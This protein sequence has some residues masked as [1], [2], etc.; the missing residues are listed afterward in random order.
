[1]PSN[2]KINVDVGVNFKAE[3]ADLTKYLQEVQSAIQDM[4]KNTGN[5]GAFSGTE[6][7]IQK[8]IES[9][10]KLKNFKLNSSN[11]VEF[12][13]NVDKL[14]NNLNNLQ[15]EFNTENTALENRA[16]KYTKNINAANE[17][18]NLHKAEIEALKEKRTEGTRLTTE[19]TKQV[20]QYNSRLALIGRMNSLLKENNLS[21]EDRKKVL[22]AVNNALRQEENVLKGVAAAN[23][24]NANNEAVANK[25]SVINAI[26]QKIEY[27]TGLA[28]SIRLLR[29]QLK[30][31]IQTFQEVDKSITSISM[32]SGIS[33]DTLWNNIGDYNKLAQ[34]LGTTTKDVLQASQ[35]YYQQGRNSL[36]VVELTRESLTLAA[37]AGLETADATNYLTAAVN[38]YKMAASDA[39]QVTDVWAQL[40]AKNAVSVKELAVSISKVASIAQSAGMDIQSTSVFLTQMIATTREAPENLGTALKTIIARFQ[41]LKTSTEALE[42]GVD[43]NKVEKALKTVGISLRDTTG[44]FRDFD[45]VILELSSKWDSLDRNT[46]RYIATI[47][48]GSRQ[49]SRFIALVS[50]YE[51]LTKIMQEAS[52]ADGASA[53]QFEI[54][55]SGLEAALKRVK[56]AWENFYLSFSKGHNIV[57]RVA[58][59]ITKILNGASKIGSGLTVALGLVSAALIR[60]GMAAFSTGSGFSFMAG[61]TFTAKVGMLAYA[62]ATGK[63]ATA[64]T[65][66]NASN[67]VG[68]VTILIGAL[69]TLIPLLSNGANK[70][71][72]LKERIAETNEKSAELAQ[73]AAQLQ[74]YAKALRDANLAGEDDAEIRQQIIAL[75][76]ESLKNL[77]LETMAY[78]DLAKAMEIAARKDLRESVKENVNNL[79]NQRE[80]ALTEE[81]NRIRDQHADNLQD[82]LDEMANDEERAFLQLQMDESEYYQKVLDRLAKERAKMPEMAWSDAR[83]IGEDILGF[84]LTPEELTRVADA[85]R[86]LG[87]SIYYYDDSTQ[88]YASNDVAGLRE[89]ATIKE[90]LENIHSEDLNKLIAEAGTDAAKNYLNS[91]LTQINEQKAQVETVIRDLLYTPSYNLSGDMTLVQTGLQQSITSAFNNLG[92]IESAAA[93]KFLENIGQALYDNDDELARQITDWANTLIQSGIDPEDVSV[94]MIDLILGSPA[95]IEEAFSQQVEILADGSVQ[96]TDLGE[97]LKTQI[98]DSTAAFLEFNSVISQTSSVLSDV[99]K[100]IGG[101]LTLDQL[102]ETIMSLSLHWEEMGYSSRAAAVEALYAASASD[103]AGYSL[104][105]ES[106]A[107]QN[108]IGWVDLSTEATREEAIEKAQAAIDKNNIRIEELK[109]EEKRVQGIINGLKL[110]SGAN[111]DAYETDATNANNF[112]R[113]ITGIA[114]R[115]S[116]ALDTILGTNTADSIGAWVDETFTKKQSE[117]ESYE[118]QLKDIQDEIHS[119]DDANAVYQSV[120]GRAQAYNSRAGRKNLGGSS[121]SNGGSGSSEKTATENT[122]KLSEAMKEAAEAAKNLAKQMQDSMK[123]EIEAAKSRLEAL[124]ADAEKRKKLAE[125][126]L[127]DTQW[128]MKATLE[129][130]KEYIEK[131]LDL[132]Q[133]KIDDEKKLLKKEQDELQ[134]LNDDLRLQADAAQDAYDLKIDFVQKQI[135]ALNKEAEAEDR[136]RKLQEARDAY[137]RSRNQRTRLVLTQGAGWIFKTDTEALNQARDGLKDAQRDYQK[138]VLQDE[139]DKYE[140]AKKQVADLANNIGESQ[141]YMN[142]LANATNEW[143]S[144]IDSDKLE[145]LILF[146]ELQS[147]VKKSNTTTDNVRNHEKEIE[148]LEEDYKAKSERAQATIDDISERIERVGWDDHDYEVQDYKNSV[149]KNLFNGDAVLSGEKTLDELLNQDKYIAADFKSFDSYQRQ[150]NKT[151]LGI[152]D[153]VESID[154]EIKN[155]NELGKNIGKNA[156]ELAK[157]QEIAKKYENASF[158]ELKST[159]SL[160]TDLK[161][162]IGNEYYNKN[163]YDTTKIE[164]NENAWYRKL[165]KD[166]KEGNIT[167]TEAAYW[168]EVLANQ[169]KEQ[170]ELEKEKQSIAAAQSGTSGGGTGS[171]VAS[172]YISGGGRT[173]TTSP[174][175]NE[176]LTSKAGKILGN[177]ALGTI[178]VPTTTRMYDEN[179]VDNYDGWSATTVNNTWN[180]HMTTNAKTQKELQAD[181]DRESKLISGKRKGLYGTR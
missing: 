50:D 173:N 146:T 103:S 31:A 72:K 140:E 139:I 145:N 40:A 44:Q 85:I 161:G 46:Q 75:Q 125:D 30:Q 137:E 43:A 27:Y 52:E 175:T 14:K 67:P 181:L 141:K 135:D 38:G 127:E 99:D 121:R 39:G 78:Y 62:A 32:V 12:A 65:M 76:H 179:T 21:E 155:W 96:L 58:N 51:G 130:E 68:W 94:K 136:L 56:A 152:E 168:L 26:K 71:D 24:E 164:D 104:N 169:Q 177:V 81:R 57:I 167:S 157:E 149:L 15:K 11:T 13:N 132:L 48:A 42:D 74:D 174:V 47:A 45:D 83:F 159:N 63:A 109:G 119:L 156:E 180:V 166:I 151:I 165:F 5:S 22:D 41:E 128:R 93:R 6:Q 100:A 143:F 18:I 33:R 138:A 2:K 20:A 106:E 66:L 1:M 89:I 79:A 160:F 176:S 60:I 8:V 110:S 28:F 114:K 87:D 35:L 113:T 163:R 131:S 111:A 150:A 23:K 29:Q 16:A 4:Q 61:Q 19:E 77:D 3:G 95:E 105:A 133:D 147:G 158:E 88:K 37:I 142:D 54:Y 102:D 80:L 36:E 86:T 98:D 101:G 107:L 134:E 115:I 162:R 84:D 97:A 82:W 9:F 123:V 124:K 178:L 144:A 120:I 116:L 122:K 126:Q 64:Q 118:A 17:Y 117:L 171:A 148:E 59:L 154:A 91:Y 170:A 69:V 53:Q 34:E 70:V 73:S 7:Q 25:Q 112:G 92:G 153:E 108:L 90:D 10:E 129:V 49:Q 172:N 55:A